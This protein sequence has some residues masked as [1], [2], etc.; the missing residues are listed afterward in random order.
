MLN[1]WRLPTSATITD[2]ELR[3]ILDAGRVYSVWN[4]IA[5]WFKDLFTIR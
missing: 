2:M 4:R 5:D 1:N 3:A